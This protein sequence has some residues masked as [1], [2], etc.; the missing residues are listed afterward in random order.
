MLYCTCRKLGSLYQKVNEIDKAKLEYYR[1]IKLGSL[2]NYDAY[3]AMANL[4]ASQNEYD[5][6]QDVILSI[7]SVQLKNVQE[8]IGNFYYDWGAKLSMKDPYEAIRKYKLALDNYRK[9]D[10]FSTKKAVKALELTYSGIADNYIA[11]GNILEA[12]KVLNLSLDAVD[13]A[14]AHYKLAQIYENKNIDTSLSQFDKA[15]KI[16]P[17]ISTYDE[18]IQL[19][20]QKGDLLKNKGNEAAAN[21]YYEKARSLD[22][23]IYIPFVAD[24]IIL[25]NLISTRFVES[26]DKKSLVPGVS[27]KIMNASKDDVNFLKVKVVF[28]SDNRNFS[29]V[30]QL[31][32]TPGTPLHADSA[33][34]DISIFS[35]NRF[36]KY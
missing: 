25:V 5:L 29:E 23:N 32:C 19:L 10:S 26:D 31:V 21:F 22:H 15:F 6:A 36:R 24:K 8:N 18:Y 27:F 12:I 34:Y 17:G 20:V 28:S 11:S 4:Y 33:T 2:V 30:E 35:K 14:T 1:A 16:N 3:F 13:N 9:A 7:K